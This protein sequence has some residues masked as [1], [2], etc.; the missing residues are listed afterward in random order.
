MK[1]G[2]YLF[3]VRTSHRVILVVLPKLDPLEGGWLPTG[4][5]G[6][7]DEEGYLY[8]RRTEDRDLIISGGENIYPAEIENILAAHP[9]I[10]EAS[11]PGKEHPEWG[12]VPIAFVVVT[13]NVTEEELA[14]FCEERLARYKVPKSFRFIDELPRNASNKLLRRKLKE[15]EST[16]E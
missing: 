9:N 13:G 10:R 8:N 2:K 7:L 3:A 4:D 5:I 12:S 11:V 6:Y 14:S 15:L 16:T 1:K